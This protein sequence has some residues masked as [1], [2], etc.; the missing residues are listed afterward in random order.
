MLP[1]HG[2]NNFFQNFH[3]FGGKQ[4]SEFFNQA[5]Y[6]E[7][8]GISTLKEASLNILSQKPPSFMR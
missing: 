4:N 2:Q 5:A 3:K 8:A 1:R 7:A 6:I